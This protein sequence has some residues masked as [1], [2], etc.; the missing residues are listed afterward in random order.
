ME[1]IDDYRLLICAILEPREDALPSLLLMDTEKCGPGKPT[2]TV[3][4]LSS[5]FSH[6]NYPLL[7]LERGVHKPSFLESMAHFH[8]DPTQQI[9]V[10]SIPSDQRC[11]VLK[12]GVLL[13]LLKD[14]EG[15]DVGWDEWMNHSVALFLPP[16][17]MGLPCSM[18]ISGCRL[19]CLYPRSNLWL[20]GVEAL[21]VYDFSLEGRAKYKEQTIDDNGALLP[22]GGREIPAMR[23][24]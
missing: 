23:F 24:L 10:L 22:T 19:F 14:R 12:V 3:F 16:R 6:P 15:T 17:R 8:Y 20:H 21:E 9:I 5:Y 11:L 1:F 2:E 7:V 4:R 13:E 18:H